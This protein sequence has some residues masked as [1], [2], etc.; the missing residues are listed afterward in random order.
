MSVA[1]G[2]HPMVRR[3][4][5]RMTRVHGR[6]RGLRAVYDERFAR[7]RCDACAHEYLLAHANWHPHLYLL[8]TDAAAS[9]PMGRSC[10]G[11]R[12]TLDG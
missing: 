1:A 3:A 4:E 12:M 7:I 6:A 11:P 2:G 10:R 8:V 5:R 9:G